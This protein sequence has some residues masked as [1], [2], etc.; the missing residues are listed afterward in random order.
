MLSCKDVVRSASD[1]ADGRLSWR[2]RMSLYLHLLICAICRRFFKQFQLASDTAA[3]SAQQPASE[4]DVAK[5]MA[6]IERES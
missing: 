4:Q 6:Q 1:Y 2:R 3:H 5:V